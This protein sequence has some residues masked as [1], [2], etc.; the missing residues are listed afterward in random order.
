MNFRWFALLG[1]ISLGINVFVAHFQAMPGYMDADYYYATAIRIAQG[2][3][4]TENFLWNYLDEPQGI[5]HPAFLYWMPLASLIGTFGMRL[6]GTISFPSARA[7]FLIITATIPP[8]TAWLAFNLARKKNT[9]LFAGIMALFPGF[10]LPYLTTTETFGLYMFLGV[11]FLLIAGAL[12]TC[13]KSLGESR[14]CEGET[15]LVTLLLGVNAGLMHLARADG[16]LWLVTGG[17]LLCCFLYTRLVKPQVPRSNLDPRWINRSIWLVTTY[18]A[19]YTL[20]MF[21]WFQRNY[22]LFGSIFP[23]GSLRAL[24][25]VDYDDLF[26]FPSS[27]LTPT[28]WLAS[29]IGNLI[30]ARVWSLVQN[31]KTMIAVQGVVI[32]L[33]LI[34]WGIWN[35]KGSIQTRLGVISWLGIWVLMTIVFP[36]QGGRGGYFHSA[37]AMQPLLWALASDGFDKFIHWGT[38]RRG[39]NYRRAWITFST[40]IVGTIIA[41]TCFVGWQRMLRPGSIW[42]NTSSPHVIYEEMDQKL[43]SVG[44][45]TNDIVMVNNP[46]GFSVITGRPA[47]VIPDGDLDT[48]FSAAR[49]YSV[50]YLILDQNYPKGL[51][52]V[53]NLSNQFPGLR[54]LGTSHGARLFRIDEH[55]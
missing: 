48:V 28:R 49:L 16:I 30:D 50:K 38:I 25:L 55:K 37:A 1:M 51:E 32:L 40:M 11:S 36:L 9:A 46:P 45:S 10:Y 8:L 7:G 44:S 17:G 3:G 31:L 52:E 34:F 29:G 43:L 21:P 42:T 39:W 22:T 13:F 2:H 24:W 12:Q 5:P 20:V 6:T 15:I 27:L 14:F 54:Y 4:W 26:I 53:Y 41:I 47:V 33:P 19:G 18:L 23:E 35:R